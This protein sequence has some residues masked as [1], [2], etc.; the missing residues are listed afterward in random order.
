ML[1]LA[2]HG[3]GNTTGKWVSLSGTHN[4]RTCSTAVDNSSLLTGPILSSQ[5]TCALGMCFLLLLL[6]FSCFGGGG[7]GV[8]FLLIFFSPLF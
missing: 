5:I 7:G 6:I 1:L 8:V 3:P 2:G 4:Q